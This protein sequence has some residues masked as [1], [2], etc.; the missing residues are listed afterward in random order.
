MEGGRIVIPRFKRQ[1][2][3]EED[4]RK[5]R[6]TRHSHASQDADKADELGGTSSIASRK[7]KAS[8]DDKQPDDKAPNPQKRILIKKAWQAPFVLQDPNSPLVRAK[9]HDILCRM[10]MLPEAWER[11]SDHDRK[12]ILSTFPDERYI[13]NP[14]TDT[15]RPDIQ[16]L[17]SDGGFRSDC[18]KFVESIGE[19]DFNEAWLEKAWEAHGRQQRGDFDEYLA[20]TFKKEWD[21]DPLPDTPARTPTGTPKQ[22][23]ASEIV[24]RGTSS[25][26]EGSK[27]SSMRGTSEDSEEGDTLDV[28]QD[29][30]KDK[31]ADQLPNLKTP[32]CDPIYELYSDE[33][34][35]RAKLISSST[36]VENH[37]ESPVGSQ[38]FSQALG[39]SGFQ[40]RP[41]SHRL[42]SSDLLSIAK[43]SDDEEDD[44]ALTAEPVTSP[45]TTTRRGATAELA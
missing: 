45:T 41:S 20:E 1:R 5:V 6:R 29:I 12:A 17:K 27:D 19:N 28:S 4:T 23:E 25:I 31:D 36:L 18:A 8:M 3:A 38:V 35:P 39:G 22:N 2:E 32:K 7:R 21:I 24:N 44:E 13:L 42:N 26:N 34:S 33:K 14:G 30:D 11:L 15:A 40:V 43:K 10:L 16:V 37:A 9:N